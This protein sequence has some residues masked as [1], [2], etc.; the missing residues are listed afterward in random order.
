MAD[1]I[2]ARI[3][4]YCNS[5]FP[6]SEGPTEYGICLEDNDFEPYTE[7]LLENS[8]YASCQEL[9]NSKQFPGKQK[10]CDKFKLAEIIKIDDDTSM[11]DLPEQ[12]IGTDNEAKKQKSVEI[13]EES[14]RKLADE[15][16]FSRG[17]DYYINGAVSAA[18]IRG[19]NELSGLCAGSRHEPY[20]VKVMLG[21]NGIHNASCTCPRGGLCKHIVAL[22][23]QYVHEPDN[24]TITPLMKS[25]LEKFSKDELIKLILDMVEMKPSLEAIVDRR[26]LLSSSSNVE[27]AK[28]RQHVEQAL[29]FEELYAVEDSLRDILQLGETMEKKG[30]ISGAGV[31]YQEVLGAL[32]S[33]YED[34]LLPLDDDGDIAILAGDCVDGLCSCL[35]ATEEESVDEGKWGV[36]RNSWLDTL[37]EAELTDIIL[38]GMDFAAGAF[39]TIL[40]NATDQEWALLETRLHNE[41]SQSSNWRRE[42]LVE[43]LGAWHSLKGQEDEMARL[44][45]EM[46]TE[47]QQMFLL[48]REGNPQEAAVMAKQHFTA[49][50][51]TIL[52]LV[53]AMAESGAAEAGAALLSELLADTKTSH[54]NYWKWLANYSQSAGDL[55]EALKWQYEVALHYHTEESYQTLREIG[56]KLQNWEQVRARLLKDLEEHKAWETLLQVALLEGEVDQALELL[57]LVPYHSWRNYREE[58]AGA[59]TEK[60]PERALILYRELAEDAIRLKERSSYRKAAQYFRKAKTIYNRLGKS[61]EWEGYIYRIKGEYT[62]YRALQDELGKAGL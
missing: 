56:E 21:G 36:L 33:C 61:A 16:S 3:C 57:P 13:T 54:P 38:G 31:V 58:V 46:G 39:D 10:A 11:G 32:C 48:L 49:Q 50:C 34:E 40:N 62:R 17:L 47:E 22:L 45:Q 4:F 59:A 15:R 35:E 8:N 7:E 14:I 30:D 43:M 60:H 25:Q 41:I 51:G 1:E 20:R 6:S 52:R 42:R 19:E 18:I 37:L 23:L 55:K 24:F 44:I 53:S 27:K 26:F 5:F 29:T 2:S 9:I 28:I 12:S